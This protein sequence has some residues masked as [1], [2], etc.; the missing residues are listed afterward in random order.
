MTIEGLKKFTARKGPLEILLAIATLCAIGSA[1]LWFHFVYA[2]P[3]AVFEGMLARN[4]ATTSFE[5]R[6]S[7]SAETSSQTEVSRVQLSGEAFAQTFITIAQDERS[8][9]TAEVLSTVN[10]DFVRYTSAGEGAPENV[11]GVWSQQDTPGQLSQSLARLVLFGTYFPMA[12][13]SQEDREEL[14]TFMDEYVVY[15]ANYET[16]ER[17]YSGG[18]MQYTYDVTVQPQTYAQFL[19]LLGSKTGL[20][21][22]TS[23]LDP[24]DYAGNAVITLR[25]TVDVL[26]RQLI[27]VQY[28]DNTSLQE[29]YSS[30]GILQPRVTLP[31]NVI[32]EQELQDRLNGVAAE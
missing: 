6:V 10:T 11:N 30:Y 7:A 8:D 24:S 27:S 5:R 26:S 3:A 15:S 4:L 32:T 31:S 13:L 16:A 12:N 20:S 2:T 17:H 1:F 21:T 18:R 25:A 22:Y 29:S 23:G 19:K 14:L 9:V 28:P